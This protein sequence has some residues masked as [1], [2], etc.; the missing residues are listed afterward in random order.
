M[1]L[2]RYDSSGIHEQAFMPTT[3]HTP[4]GQYMHTPNFPPP[5][6]TTVKERV[7]AINVITA[8]EQ[9]TVQ[10]NIKPPAVPHQKYARSKTPTYEL[11]TS[12]EKYARS[13]TPD[14]EVGMSTSQTT[15]LQVAF[16]KRSSNELDL[17]Q[18]EERVQQ[19][20]QKQKSKGEFVK[21]HTYAAGQVTTVGDKSAYRRQQERPYHYA[22]SQDTY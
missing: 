22:G 3:S 6:P 1:D 20:I 10:Y 7:T 18:Y 15:E 11:V 21:Q 4:P 8:E 5:A 2:R 9:H 16:N 17:F 19:N 13:R 12:T 14:F